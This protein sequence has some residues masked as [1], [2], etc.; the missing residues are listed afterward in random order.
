MTQEKR[1]PGEQPRDEDT[2]LTPDQMAA[3]AQ[4]LN[5]QSE[6]EKI[7]PENKTQPEVQPRVTSI[8]LAVPD[9]IEYYFK[10]TSDWKPFT[11][12]HRISI[13]EVLINGEAVEGVVMY[14]IERQQ[15]ATEDIA[16]ELGNNM[17]DI[18]EHND[19]IPYQFLYESGP[20]SGFLKEMQKFA[21]LP[22]IQAMADKINSQGGWS[23]TVNQYGAVGRFLVKVAAETTKVRSRIFKDFKSAQAFLFEV[24]RK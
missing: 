18:L 6:E 22:E 12:A 24:L 3:M 2:P 15:L 10:H 11:E 1:K 9:S 4:G 23:L 17:L 19:K 13:P 20:S 21:T 8:D 5:T 7:K 14:C 16:R